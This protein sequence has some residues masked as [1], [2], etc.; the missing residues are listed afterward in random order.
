MWNV[1]ATGLCVLD[2][3]RQGVCWSQPRMLQGRVPVGLDDVTLGFVVG[4][5]GRRPPVAL[6]VKHLAGEESG[7]AAPWPAKYCIFIA[8][9]T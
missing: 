1:A 7:K 6:L 3:G 5:L 8:K 4:P 9:C 2:A